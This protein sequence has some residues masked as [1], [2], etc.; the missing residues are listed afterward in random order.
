MLVLGVLL[1]FGCCPEKGRAE[2]AQELYLAFSGQSYAALYPCDCEMTPD[3]GVSRRASVIKAARNTFPRFLVVE[4]GS[5]V[6]SGKDDPNAQSPALDQQRSDLYLKTLKAM[7]YDAVLLDRQEFVFGEEFLKGHSDLPWV[8]ANDRRLGVSSLLKDVKGWKIGILG[9]SDAEQAV[10]GPEEIQ[11][12]SRLL[13][14]EIDLLKN[15]GARLVVLL[16]AQKPEDDQKLLKVLKGVDIVI[17]GSPFLGT[18]QAFPM[19]SVTYVQTWWQA[20][21]LPMLKVRFEGNKMLSAEIIISRL[22]AEIPQDSDIEVLLPSCFRNEDCR[23]IPGLASACDKGGTRQARCSYVELPRVTLS[24]IVPSACRTCRKEAVLQNL[25]SM[26]G[27]VS[28]VELKETDP[29]AQKL[30]KDFQIRM[31]PAYVFHKDIETSEFFPKYKDNLEEK[32]GFYM[33]K[34]EV[35]GVSYLAG[36]KK[37]PGRVD[38]FYDLRYP[39]LPQLFELLK[40]FS[41]RHKD[42]RVELHFLAVWNEEKGFLSLGGPADIEEFKRVS[43]GAAFNSADKVIDYNICRS[44]QADAG[45]WDDCASKAKMDPAQIKSCALSVKGVGLLKERLALTQELQIASGPTFV[46]DNVEIFGIVNVPSVE[47]FEKTVVSS[48][49]ERSKDKRKP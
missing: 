9:L 44:R 35:A 39:Q 43:C 48:D 14:K 29:Q 22:S 8:S 26:W 20:R 45:W 38:V 32:N 46:I 37:I 18:V 16:S 19:E 23:R 3:G 1:V 11:K 24:M 31:L 2:E 33:I 10:L 30:I 17:N 4:A 15:S 42:V 34:P 41:G 27:K 36:R 13:Q 49:E 7:G 5:S 6:G 28:V 40:A 47:E 21:N 12:L 25:E